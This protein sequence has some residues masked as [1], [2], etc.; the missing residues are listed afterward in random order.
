M[1]HMHAIETHTP[2]QLMGSWCNWQHSGLLIRTVW[3]RFPP[4]LLS[5]ARSS[6]VRAASL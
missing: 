4:A 1:M 5:L 6:A 2:D 3:V